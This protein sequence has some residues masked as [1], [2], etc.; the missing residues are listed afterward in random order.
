MTRGH[1][2]PQTAHRFLY[3]ATLLAALVA[4]VAT[5]L[6]GFGVPAPDDIGGFQ[7]SQY[8][9]P[10]SEFLA[11]ITRYPELVLRFFSAD[12]L[13]VISYTVVFVGLA[14]FTAQTARPL[15]WLG[16]G[17][18]LLTAAFDA[19]ENGFY[20]VYATSVL[21]GAEITD[22]AYTVLIM[23]TYLKWMAAFVAFAAF[24]LAWPRDG[25]LNWVIAALM[26][27]FPLV[28]VLGIA[29]GGVLFE[30]RGLYFLIGFPLFALT[31]WRQLRGSG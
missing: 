21:N 30:L 13:F 27:S 4:F 10:L 31:F 11:P 19:T 16:L 26:V 23:L 28:G 22:P 17:A 3:Q 8:P 14:V 18:G 7:M 29:F 2:P 5:I 24:G 12:T 15:A 25:V 6:M 20:I 9:G 1:L